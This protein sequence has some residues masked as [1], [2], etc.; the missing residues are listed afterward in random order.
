[1]F[2]LVHVGLGGRQVLRHHYVSP[3]VLL[4]NPHHSLLNWRSE[5]GRRRKRR[6]PDSN[7]LPIA[8]RIR[9]SESCCCG[10]SKKLR[11][12]GTHHPHPHP[13][14]ARNSRHLPT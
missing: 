7:F 12:L 9:P 4:V 2:E 8:R 3:G 14:Q 11:G 6:P 10:L 1:M 5:C 13:L